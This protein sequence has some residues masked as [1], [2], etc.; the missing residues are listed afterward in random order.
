[1]GIRDSPSA[2]S[3]G[4]GFGVEGRRLVTGMAARPRGR[5]SRGNAEAGVGL[6]RRSGPPGGGAPVLVP[7]PQ[8]Q[9]GRSGRAKQLGVGVKEHVLKIFEVD[10][11][12]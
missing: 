3:K 9:P 2:A 7:M 4:V 5:C 11:N 12:T 6:G 8:R 10:K 1:M